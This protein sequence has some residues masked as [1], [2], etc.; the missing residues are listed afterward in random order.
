MSSQLIF[1]LLIALVT[2][3]S[4]SAAEEQAPENP[5]FRWTARKPTKAADAGYPKLPG[6]EIIHLLRDQ[7]GQM[8]HLPILQ[9][10]QSHFFL[11]TTHHPLSHHES[12]QGRNCRAWVSDGE[13]NK[14]KGPLE[15]LPPPD[16]VTKKIC[17]QL[18]HPEKHPIGFPSRFVEASD[19][20]IYGV[21]RLGYKKRPGS[22]GD[23]GG[24]G[25]NSHHTVGFVAREI[26][27]DGL[28]SK[29]FWAMKKQST[30]QYPR[31]QYDDRS[32]TPLGKELGDIAYDWI[33][34]GGALSPSGIRYPK[35][36]RQVTPDGASITE[37]TTAW[38]N[39][40][41][42]ALG[43]PDS[44]SKLSVH[45]VAWSDDGGR[46]WSPFMR[47]EIPTS[48][49]GSQLG[50]L[51]NGNLYLVGALSANRLNQRTPLAIAISKDGQTFSKVWAVFAKKIHAIRNTVIHD[52]YIWVG[53]CHG[54]RNNGRQDVAVVKIPI[55]ALK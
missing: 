55:K 17:F 23:S 10:L 44:S 28:M 49:N 41:A 32:D 12:A 3:Q 1:N 13:G 54:R 22:S 40:R 30:K 9:R 5:V 8:N 16:E 34:A 2:A 24:D 20:R 29:P 53:I 42:V 25:R 45:Y 50:V 33:P 15:L 51:P 43:R 36:W 26:G 27:P 21:T 6:V 46:N 39:G 31:L 48:Q 35:P 38:V 37:F 47:T 7:E 52:G 4:L 11:M 19:G 18:R 14:W